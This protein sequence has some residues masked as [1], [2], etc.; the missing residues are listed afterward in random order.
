MKKL[1]IDEQFEGM[2]LDQYMALVLEDYSRNVIQTWI[3]DG[4]I[5]VNDKT[6]KRNHRLKE[7]DVIAYVITEADTTITPV[8]MDLDIVYEDDHIMVVNKPKGLIVHPSPS[9]LN[10]PTLVHG[11]LAHTTQL[12]DCNGELRPG[13]VHRIDKDTSGLLVV[14]KTNEAHEILVEDLKQRKIS[15]EYLAVVHH[16]FP[17]Q[18]ATVDAPIGRDPRSRQRMAVTDKNSKEAITH[19]FLVEKFNDYSI[20]RAKLDTG[21]T[22]QIRVHCSYIKH[23]IVGDQTYSY[24]NTMDTQGQCLH[25]FKLKLNHPITKE[26]LEFECEMPQVM[27]DAIE[28]I[29]RL[30]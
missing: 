17:H 7:E 27:K 3:E 26:V 28:E 2:R 29:R 21:R 23:P 6:V 20:L 1:M 19:L 10:Q 4:K 15:R 12:S 8:A 11:L 18:S 14:A 9:T 24:K 30:D 13:I 22:H 16:P 5:T 25:A